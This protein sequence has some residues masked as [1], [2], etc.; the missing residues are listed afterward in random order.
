MSSLLTEHFGY[1]SDALRLR[2]Y[3]EAIAAVVR[4][5]DVVVDIGCG[6]GVLGLACLRAF[7]RCSLT[8]DAGS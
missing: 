1:L 2:R 3:G 7:S 6:S 4:E 8:P 5:G